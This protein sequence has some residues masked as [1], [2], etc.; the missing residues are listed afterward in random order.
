MRSHGGD[1]HLNH[2][3]ALLGLIYTAVT[4]KFF[5]FLLS[6]E[7]NVSP[8]PLPCLLSIVISS[9]KPTLFRASTRNRCGRG[10]CTCFV[11]GGFSKTMASVLCYLVMRADYVA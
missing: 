6:R 2:V 1:D 5:V 4:G 11:L 8:S 3:D 10:L 7:P 9:S